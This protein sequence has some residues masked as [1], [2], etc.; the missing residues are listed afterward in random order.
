MDWD[1]A[2]RVARVRVLALAAQASAGGEPS[3]R[4]VRH[5]LAP[6]IQHVALELRPGSS[7][8]GTVVKRH[9]RPRRDSRKRVKAV[10]S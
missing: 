3:D 6:I 8:E 1:T 5:A 7:S 9:V 4:Q 10:L 2:C